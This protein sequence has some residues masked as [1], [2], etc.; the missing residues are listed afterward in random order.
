MGRRPG[1][2]T[3]ECVGTMPTNE[4]QALF[5]SKARF[6]SA[7]YGPGG[8]LNRR[9][10]QFA[11]RLCELS[12]SP[13]RILDL[14]CGTGEI[15]AALCEKGYQVTACDIAER[16][17]EVARADRG[18][19]PIT[20]IS[21]KPGWND[22]PFETGSFDGI[23]A[24]S[25]FEYLTDVQGMVAE[26]SRVLR[27]TGV[28]VFSVPNPYS[29]IRRLEKWLSSDHLLGNLPP[30]ILRI[31]RVKSYVTYLQISRNRFGPRGWQRILAATGFESVN[32]TDFSNERW[33][34]QASAP[35]IL[36]AA[37]KQTTNKNSS[38]STVNKK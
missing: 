24:S 8:E 34:E 6:W 22:L 19:M 2:Q 18:E 4:V 13:G 11:T 31:R 35:L 3:K 7:K 16:M 27:P 15:S 33:L 23:V 29:R 30:C 5:N 1:A 26:L 17:L 38:A 28:L 32:E 21:L 14:G 25:V 37:K 12:P 20:W 10:E 9:L 36:L